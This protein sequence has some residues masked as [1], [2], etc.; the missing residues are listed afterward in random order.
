MLLLGITFTVYLPFVV[1]Y[2]S[3][4]LVECL[5]L[6]IL[7]LRRASKIQKLSVCTDS[8]ESQCVGICFY[9]V[10]ST[11]IAT[12]P[13]PIRGIWW[14]V[15]SSLNRIQIFR[16]GAYFQIMCRH[17]GNHPL[18]FIFLSNCA[19]ISQSVQAHIG[20]GEGLVSVLLMVSSVV[21]NCARVQ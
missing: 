7:Q 15:R 4:Y 1:D 17:I 11:G 10:N 13:D 5:Y 16:L 9:Q 12:G 8:E 18:L 3:Y 20:G 21:L 14:S 6:L 2:I 19:C